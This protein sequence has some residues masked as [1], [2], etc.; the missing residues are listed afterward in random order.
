LFILF[1]FPETKGRT[2]EEMDE[3]FG[4]AGSLAAADQARLA[5][6]NRRLGLD[7][8]ASSEKG[9]DEKREIA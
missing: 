1:F 7:Q 6:I 5:D 4:A 2:L 9:Q 3:L 8:Y